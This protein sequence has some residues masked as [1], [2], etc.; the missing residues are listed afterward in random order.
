M[1]A[2]ATASVIAIMLLGVLTTPDPA[3]HSTHE[4][5]GLPPCW[6]MVAAG[7][8]CPGC[9]VTTAVSHLARGEWRAG[10]VTQPFG[11]LLAAGSVLGFGW[12][13]LATLLGRDAWLDSRRWSRPWMYWSVGAAMLAA[14]AYKLA[15]LST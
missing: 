6:L 14:W 15:V 9:G 7:V 1:L 3:G 8:P 13:L 5:L 2:L 12:T 10:I 4:Q 11:A